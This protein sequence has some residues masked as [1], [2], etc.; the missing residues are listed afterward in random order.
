MLAPG[1]VAQLVGLCK[2]IGNEVTDE[3][4]FVAVRKLVSRFHAKLLIQ[5]L[6]VEAM[7]AYRDHGSDKADDERWAVL[8]DSEAFPVSME[9]IGEERPT[10]PLPQR[11]R[12]TI[13]H[14]LV[15]SLAFR[16]SEFGIR[17]KSRSEE[18]ETPQD[19]IDSI[20][21]ETESLSPFLLWSQSAL[22]GTL[23]GRANA[24]SLADL[25]DVVEKMGI[26]RYVLINRLTYLE[27]D[28]ES[29]GLLVSRALR[30]LAI[31]LGVWRH[32]GTLLKGWP[33]F[34]N[35]DNG[36]IPSFLFKLFDNNFVPANQIFQGQSL[37]DNSALTGA[38]RFRVSAGTKSVPNAKKMDVE[39]E[40]EDINHREDEEFLFVIRRIENG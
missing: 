13:A 17:L 1:D 28:A 4:G 9:D 29:A 37:S 14:E 10:K 22:E 39:I 38:R 25:V 27:R 11:M 24:L 31:G 35:F 12:N 20:E 2:A 26:S 19:L 3:N 30:N 16:T 36:I 8:V 7:V 40:I 5:P 32:E 15:H 23:R 34:W 6:L 18:N 21:D 33:I